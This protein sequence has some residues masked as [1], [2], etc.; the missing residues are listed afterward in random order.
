MCAWLKAFAPGPTV[1]ELQGPARQPTP[2]K[3][4]THNL[5]HLYPYPSPPTLLPS[6]PP[7]AQVPLGRPPRDL[8]SVRVSLAPLTPSLGALKSVSRMLVLTARL[9]R[10]GRAPSAHCADGGLPLCKASHWRASQSRDLNAGILAPEPSLLEL[11]S[12]VFL[13]LES[14]F[15]PHP[16][17]GFPAPSLRLSAG[18][19][20]RLP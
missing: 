17:P 8:A 20:V 13:L 5:P 6:Q 12:R 15:C 2:G 9:V 4:K 1:I 3:T 11:M 7:S 19:H 18:L 10:G 14:L 16:F